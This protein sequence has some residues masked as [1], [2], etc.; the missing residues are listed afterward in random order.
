MKKVAMIVGVSLFVAV[1][2]SNLMLFR[3]LATLSKRVE[4]VSLFKINLPPELQGDI[5]K[6]FEEIASNL[7]DMAKQKIADNE[8][9]NQ[10]AMEEAQKCFD[11]T[12]RNLGTAAEEAKKC[13]EEIAN[14]LSDMAK[15]KIA[16]N[17]TANQK[18]V[19]EAQKR[20][21]EIANSLSDMAKQKIMGNE[22]A[23]EEAF[24]AAQQFVENDDLVSAKIYCLNAI[25]HA[26][27]QKRYFEE[28]V[29]I[30]KATQSPPSIDDLDPIRSVLELGIYQVD[31]KDIP[32]MSQM[33]QDVVEEIDAVMAKLATER[34][35]Q[36]REMLAQLLAM[37]KSGELSWDKLLELKKH[38][39]LDP[40]R[41]RM[42]TLNELA[43]AE[44][45]Q[46][47][48]AWVTDEIHKTSTLIDYTIAETTIDNYLGKAEK[49]LSAGNPKEQLASVSSMVQTANNVLSQ[50]WSID[51]DALPKDS[52]DALSKHGRRIEKI[53]TTFN[54]VK[55]ADALARI[56][57]LKNE[58]SAI[59]QGYSSFTFRIN[60]IQDKAKQ[61]VALLPEVYD[62]D[63]QKAIEADLSGYQKLVE[64]NVKQRYKKY[65]TWAV[66]KCDDAFKLYDTYYSGAKIMSATQA[67]EIIDKH[68]K[69]IDESL[70]SFAVGKL[71]QDLLGKQLEQIGG[72]KVA[73]GEGWKGVAEYQ[74][75]LAT[76]PKK[77]L[78]DF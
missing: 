48:A 43:N 11:E 12:A 59:N 44:L 56:Q 60:T 38:D 50:S 35:E 14:N 15:Q 65:Q 24:K 55:S 1:V 75:V 45:P 22:I 34:A 42:E 77:T 41:A 46:E 9:A 30:Q 5:S 67:K 29:K 23:A 53:E 73:K 69:E 16:D 78:E 25:N 72:F 70:L 36:N 19:E 61:I 17:E 6:R 52:L 39:V 40:A 33:L 26:P 63:A 20:F 3:Q 28:L 49:L 18:T 54:Q 57:A 31:S 37:T 27:D 71:Y 58:I 32:A 66:D 8:T 4:E 64:D 2:G 76:W 13:F 7:S 68:L 10:K 21:E 74:K 62:R 51:F 47:D